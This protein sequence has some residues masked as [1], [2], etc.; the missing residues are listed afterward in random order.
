M[1]LPGMGAG[2]HSTDPGGICGQVLSPA[3]APN[4]GAEHVMKLEGKT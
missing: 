4:R 3:G 2:G 1:G